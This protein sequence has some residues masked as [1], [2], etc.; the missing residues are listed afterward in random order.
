M[1]SS[2]EIL[3]LM[4]KMPSE[5]LALVMGGRAPQPFTVH[6]TVRTLQ[7]VPG[8]WPRLLGH[9]KSGPSKMA[10]H[11]GLDDPLSWALWQLWYELQHEP[12]S[13]WVTQVDDQLH[14][15]V[16]LTACYPHLRE[17]YAREHGLTCPSGAS[18]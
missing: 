12:V 15:D 14:L 9:M 3:R 8:V 5:I 11:L 10:Q 16:T 6:L 18:V 4:E 13:D 1:N 17:V 7:A 2:P